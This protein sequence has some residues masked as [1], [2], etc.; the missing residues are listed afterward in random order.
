VKDLM[1]M[2]DRIRGE[3]VKNLMLMLDRIRGEQ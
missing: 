1:L 3:T 2:L